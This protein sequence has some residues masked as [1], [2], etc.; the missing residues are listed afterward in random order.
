M[1]SVAALSEKERFGSSEHSEIRYAVGNKTNL[2]LFFTDGLFDIK[3]Q[4]K[5][6]GNRVCGA[7][8]F[9]RIFKTGVRWRDRRHFR[10]YSLQS[11]RKINSIIL[12]GF[13]M[14]Y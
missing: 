14:P 12:K 11:T 6:D 2:L 5:L 13:T 7:L 3:S 1:A 4:K 10:H 8:L 9:H